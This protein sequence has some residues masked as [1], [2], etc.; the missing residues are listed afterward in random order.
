MND[1]P[2]AV[3]S[4]RSWKTLSHT[5]NRLSLFAVATI[6]VTWPVLLSATAAADPAASPGVPCL[7]M[8]QSFAAAPS[9]VPDALQTAASVLAPPAPPPP[10]AQPAPPVPLTS[11]LQGLTAL[12]APNPAPVPPPPVAAAPLVDGA[13]GVP[14]AAP[15]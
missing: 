13:G 8:M 14:A 7:S 3:P 1:R 9:T 2:V 11:L 10:A 15:S 6:S 12:A 5:T 4:P